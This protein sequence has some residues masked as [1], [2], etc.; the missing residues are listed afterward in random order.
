M[1]ES[2]GRVV[3]FGEAMIRLTPPF[4]ERVERTR[5]LNLSPGG[6]E[7][8]TS[9]TLACLGYHA[10]WVSVLPD[11][12]LGRFIV[13]EGRRAG[14]DMAPAKLTPETEGRMGL[15]FLEEGTDPRPSAVT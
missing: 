11:T 14:V 3:T 12:G 1:S 2:R 9:V 7:L 10:Q 15:Y 13:R 5:S 4:N 8:N 6:A